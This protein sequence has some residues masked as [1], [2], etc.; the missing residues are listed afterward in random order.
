M[1]WLTTHC[2]IFNLP[3]VCNQPHLSFKNLFQQ[4]QDY[5]NHKIF[6]NKYQASQIWIFFIMRSLWAFLQPKCCSWAHPSSNTFMS[7][8]GWSLPSRLAERARVS[9]ACGASNLNM[10]YSPVGV[11]KL[12]QKPLVMLPGT[13]TKKINKPAQEEDAAL[14]AQSHRAAPMLGMFAGREVGDIRLS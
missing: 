1:Q 9:R 7:Q 3:T 8:K 6:I 11:C 5:L 14:A 13:S 10:L 12:W 2:I 4:H